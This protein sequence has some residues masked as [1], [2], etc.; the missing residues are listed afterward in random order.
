MYLIFIKTY[1]VPF[2]CI[3]LLH[4]IICCIIYE[5]APPLFIKLFKCYLRNIKYTGGFK[6]YIV[7]MAL[8]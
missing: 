7:K 8:E 2:Y 6:T 3:M 5:S 4:I 1:V